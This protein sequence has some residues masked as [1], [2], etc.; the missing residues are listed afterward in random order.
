MA[1]TAQSSADSVERTARSAHGSRAVEVLARLGLASRATVWLVIGLLAASVVVGSGDEQADQSGALRAI[2]DKPLG[3]VMLAVLAIGFVGYAVWRLLSAA[4]GHREDDGASRLGRRIGSLGTGLLYLFLAVS[5]LLFLQRGGG[6]DQT[7]SRTAELMSRPGGRTAV[8]VVGAGLIVG[9]L[10]VAVRGV[11]Q[12]H[13]DRL[14]NYRV[15]DGL[16][17]P[18]VAIGVVGMVGRG[19]VAV[20]I[21]VFLVR[22]AA[23]FDPEEAKGLDAALQALA[24]QPFGRLMLAVAV[25][26]M[27][28]YAAWSYVEAAYR[29]V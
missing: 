18:A 21:G 13:G 10:V 1:P 22:A 26:G 14:E 23:L 28:A 9:G 25:V 27:L 4:V 24:G 11:L 20:L 12:K 3:G 2:V 29:Q 15:P 17:R 8:A 19:G 16:R 5:T 7:T 6:S